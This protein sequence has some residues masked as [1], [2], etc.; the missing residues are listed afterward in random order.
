MEQVSNLSGALLLAEY[1]FQL[2]FNVMRHFSHCAP[3][4]NVRGHG[5]HC[6]QD[7]C[8]FAQ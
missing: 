2:L 5:T 8:V 3:G 7:L 4:D 6:P 1:D